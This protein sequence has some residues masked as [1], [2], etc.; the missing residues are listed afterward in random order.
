MPVEIHPER[1]VELTDLN[2]DDR[3]RLRE[4]VGAILFAIVLFGPLLY[5]VKLYAAP[6]FKNTGNDGQPVSLRLLDTPCT[7]PKVSAH[8]KA[9][10]KEEFI[11]K[12]KSAVLYYGGKH[13]ASCWVEFNGFV[14]SYD[15]EGAPFNPPTGIPRALFQEDTV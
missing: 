9:N 8:L 2:K 5:A 1:T 14:Y 12:F 13:W 6:L 4:I 15:E 10:V 7:D 11:P 3:G